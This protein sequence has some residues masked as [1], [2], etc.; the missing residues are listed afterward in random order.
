[1]DRVLTGAGNF[2]LHTI[3]SRLALGPTQPHIKYI[4]GALF[5]VVKRLGREAEHSPPS[6]AEVNN[7]WSYTSTPHYALI[8][9]CSVKKSTGATL[10]LPLYYCVQ[11]GCRAHQL[12][13]AS[14]MGV[15]GPK[16]EASKSPQ[17]SAEF[18]NTWTYTSTPTHA[19]TEQCLVRHRDNFKFNFFLCIYTY[20]SQGGK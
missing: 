11:T 6:S 18:R 13:E 20:L 14:S 16:R 2:L 1:V 8:A 12:P 9:W 5:L 3:V 15:K 17:S 19:F 7:A 10:P 4:P